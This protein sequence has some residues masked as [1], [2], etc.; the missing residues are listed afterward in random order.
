MNLLRLVLL[1]AVAPLGLFQGCDNASNEELPNSGQ[2]LCFLQYQECIDPIFH[3]INTSGGSCSQAGCHDMT[4]SSGG[5]F[6]IPGAGA[7]S[8]EMMTNFAQVESRTLNNNL[9]FSKAALLGGTPHGGGQRLSQGDACYNAIQEWQGIPAPADGSDCVP[10]NVAGS[11]YALCV[12]A[13]LAALCG[14]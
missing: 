1:A 5:F 7:G 10:G 8:A 14:P 6:L 12:N 4:T 9:L 13:A 2:S 3:T 11:P